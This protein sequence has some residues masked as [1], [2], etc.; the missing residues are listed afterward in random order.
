M[1]NI[2]IILLFLTPLFSIAESKDVLKVETKKK[3]VYK[4]GNDIINV[5][6]YI[7]TLKIKK[8]KTTLC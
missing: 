8:R 3:V 5:D 7:K 4:K 2:I 1:K 6:F